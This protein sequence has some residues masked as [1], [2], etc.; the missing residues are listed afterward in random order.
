VIHLDLDDLLQV[1]QRTLGEV[2]VP[3][4]GLLGAAAR[5]A[6]GR[7]PRCCSEPALMHRYPGRHRDPVNR[8]CDREEASAIAR[9]RRQSH[10]VAEVFRPQGVVFLSRPHSPYARPQGR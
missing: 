8:P 9:L 10:L 6:R 1:A 5:S 4:L 7:L 3:D 2:Q